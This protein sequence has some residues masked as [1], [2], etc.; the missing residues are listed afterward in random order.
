MNQLQPLLVVVPEPT[1]EK[2][3][4]EVKIPRGKAAAPRRS[5]KYPRSV[6]CEWV[7]ERD[8]TCTPA[9]PRRHRWVQRHPFGVDFNPRGKVRTR[10]LAPGFRSCMGCGQRGPFL[11]RPVQ[12]THPELQERGWKE[13][14]RGAAR[15][16]GRYR[17]AD[18]MASR[19]P[20][21]SPR[22]ACWEPFVRR[23]P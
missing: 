23:N 16:P 2:A 10:E 7:K 19:T 13:A 15:L 21:R 9:P 4:E 12:S 3:F 1:D 5:K 22:R 11:S 20:S 8:V 17:E 18:P 6:A 14:R